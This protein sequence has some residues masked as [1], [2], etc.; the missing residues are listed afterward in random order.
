MPRVMSEDPKILTGLME[1][2]ALEAA[3]NELA[4]MSD[5]EQSRRRGE[6]IAQHGDAALTLLLTKL[7]T[8]DPQLRGGLGQVA[9]HLERDA[10]VAALRNVARSAQH[11]DHARLSALTILDRYLHETVDD[12]LLT[13]LQDPEII[14]RESLAEL[15]REMA[16]SPYS[17]IEY[18]A[19]LSEQPPDV[20][21]LILQALPALQPDPHLITLLRMLAQEPD[22]DVARKAIEQLGRVRDSAAARA[23]ASLSATLPDALAALAER[24]LRKLRMSGVAPVDADP[25][26]E[27]W[28]A[29]P[30]T[31]RMLL[32]AVDPAGAQMLW[33]ISPIDPTG[34]CRLLSIVIQDA[35]GVI[36]CTDLRHVLAADLPPP[37]PDG[38]IHH[39]PRRTGRRTTPFLETRFTTGAQI[40]REA[41]PWNWRS[42]SPPPPPYRLVNPSIWLEDDRADNADADAH[43][44]PPIGVAPDGD[45]AILLQHPAFSGWR[46]RPTSP[47]A[48]PVRQQTNADE[49]LLRLALEHFGP[50][51]RASYTRRLQTMG[52]WL[53]LA[54]DAETAALAVA[55]ATQLEELEPAASSFVIQLVKAGFELERPFYSTIGT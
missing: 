21:Y 42:N 23:L 50:E 48:K 10:V 32:S 2:R 44:E 15:G 35:L 28:S 27:P 36:G 46:W 25:A 47:F 22:P 1:R 9:L 3:F 24:N 41:I 49:T 29:P 51:E 13:G 5:A 4:E 33:F 7:D 38:F 6:R 20:P 31:G 17:I 53:A 55:A 14:A 34:R 8:D 40:L 16:R 52:R 43:E 54:G 37:R 45:P 30:V 39:I 18:L 12:E 19:Q 11:T 26:I